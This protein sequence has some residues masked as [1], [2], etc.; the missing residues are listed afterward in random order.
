MDD[1]S[2]RDMRVVWCEACAREF[3]AYKLRHDGE[4]W[5]CADPKCPGKGTGY[6]LH[7]SDEEYASG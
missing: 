7:I 3:P 5:R 1:P 2:M 4:E 6:D